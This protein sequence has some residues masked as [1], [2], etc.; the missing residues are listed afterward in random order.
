MKYHQGRLI[1]HIGIH[2]SDLAASKS[3]YF[4]ILEALEKTEGFGGDDSCFYF[5]ELYVAAGKTPVTNLHLAFQA[6]SVDQVHA[7]HEAGLAAG[8]RD[9]GGPGYRSEYHDAY[10]AAFLLDPDG[11]N[12]EA[13]CDVGAQRSSASVE[14]TRERG[15]T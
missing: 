2:V 10:Y 4:A 1:D 7:F 6:S 11:N 14:I 12:V 9:N 3:F 13:I 15:D 8:G 5:D